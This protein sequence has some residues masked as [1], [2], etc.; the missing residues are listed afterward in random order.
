MSPL[1]GPELFNQSVLLVLVEP[2]LGRL[3]PVPHALA[4]AFRMPLACRLADLTAQ[5]KNQG[6]LAVIALL[7][8]RVADLPMMVVVVEP[9]HETLT[10]LPGLPDVGNATTRV[11][12]HILERAKPRLDEGPKKTTTILPRG[13]D[14]GAAHAE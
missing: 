13:G 9:A 7:R 6:T 10:P 8:G 11:A 2:D 12:R 4:S 5:L 3:L 1:T 14:S